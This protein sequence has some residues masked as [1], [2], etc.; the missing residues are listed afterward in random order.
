MR[1]KAVG[2]SCR[3]DC[4][5]LDT[6]GTGGGRAGDVQHLDGGGAGGRRG[7]RCGP[8]AETFLNEALRWDT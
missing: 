2:V 5:V 7:G 6:C 4:V 3:D 8:G 1:E